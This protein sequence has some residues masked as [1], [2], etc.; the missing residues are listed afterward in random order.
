LRCQR[1]SAKES[2]AQTPLARLALLLLIVFLQ[3][4]VAR[5]G[6]IADLRRA[7]VVEDDLRGWR[8]D[9]DAVGEVGEA[10]NVDTG[11][12]TESS[13]ADDKRNF[14]GGGSGVVH[15]DGDE[16]SAVVTFARGKLAGLN[17]D[18]GEVGEAAVA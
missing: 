8:F 3:N 6:R 16:P 10:R 7:A 17:V 15:G 9:Q 2:K 4:D 14:D 1:S 12:G 18:D 11:G 13:G 5:V